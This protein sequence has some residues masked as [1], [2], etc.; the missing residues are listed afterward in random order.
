MDDHQICELI[1]DSVL[2]RV[3]I[4]NELIVTVDQTSLPIEMTLRQSV[5]CVYSCINKM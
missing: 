5:L 1:Q 3:E 2:T 4:G